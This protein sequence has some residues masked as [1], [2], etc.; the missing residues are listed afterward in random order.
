MKPEVHLLYFEG[1][2][3]FEKAK[4]NLKA[5]IDQLGLSL[6]WREVNLKDPQ[7][8]E[9]WR[10]FPSPTILINGS[11]LITGATASEGTSSCRFGG[12]PK[13]E[14]IAAKLQSNNPKSLWASLCA[15]PAALIGLFLSLFCPACYP[16]LAGLIG[17][18]GLGTVTEEALLKPLMILFLLVALLGLA[19]QGRRRGRYGPLI[20]G[21]M[22]ALGMYG[23]FYFFAS[24][25]LKS[26]GLAALIAASLWNVFP[27][28]RFNQ[29]ENCPQ[30]KT[31]G[32]Q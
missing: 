21:F 13:A 10:G 29:K 22:G 32:V 14:L 30:C 2:P 5:A 8:P 19:Y 7:T 9:A 4:E 24:P 31:G 17:S 27:K 1:C 20:L 23:G 28:L 26:I 12:A 16:A 18:I 11:E 3:N 15:V 6:Q 25:L